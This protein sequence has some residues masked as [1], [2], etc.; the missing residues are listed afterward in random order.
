[1]IK[2]GLT[3]GIGVGKTY[4]SKIFQK[5]GVPVFNADN[6]AKLCM[7]NDLTLKQNIES[8]FGKSIY[9]DGVLQRKKLAEIVFNDTDALIK[10]NKLVHPVVKKSFDLWCQKQK[11]KLIIKEAAILFE[12]KSDKDLDFVICVSAPFDERVRRLKER[13]RCSV[14]D[15][16]QRISQQ[17]DEDEKQQ[18]SNFIITNDSKQLVLPQIINIIKEIE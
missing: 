13:D 16:K 6:H 10:L 17:M 15:I 18:L 9:F 14:N 8:Q 5:L 2:I 1:M 7:I 3:G 12:S 4:V 11:T